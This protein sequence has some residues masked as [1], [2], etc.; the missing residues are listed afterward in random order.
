MAAPVAY[1]SSQARGQIG[2]T[3]V[4][5]TAATPTP[6]PSHICDLNHSLRQYQTLKPTSKARD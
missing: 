6:D 2:P 5:Y 1:G 3:A 4:A